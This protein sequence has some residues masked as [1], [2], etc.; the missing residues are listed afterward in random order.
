MGDNVTE[1]MVEPPDWKETLFKAVEMNTSLDEW[2]LLVNVA[3]NVR[4]VDSSFDPRT[5]GKAK[6]L[7]L[8]RTA[9][10]AFKVREEKV[11]GQPPVHYI[12]AISR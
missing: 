12:K 6:L 4:K 1:I 9:S 5:Y 7:T 11:D 10:E 8:I 2:H 3:H